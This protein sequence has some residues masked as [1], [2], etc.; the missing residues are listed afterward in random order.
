MGSLSN[1]LIPSS[2]DYPRYRRLICGNFENAFRSE[3]K[4]N[5]TVSFRHGVSSEISVLQRAHLRIH[6]KNHLTS[7]GLA[8]VA[9]AIDTVNGNVYLVARGRW[10]ESTTAVP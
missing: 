6:L 4:S 8:D 9:V 3:S 2:F 10:L 7:I 5:Q 1:T